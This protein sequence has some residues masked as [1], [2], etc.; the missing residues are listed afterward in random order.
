MSSFRW[1]GV[2]M[3][4]TASGSTAGLVGVD[5]FFSTRISGL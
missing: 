4:L 1:G 3:R 5:D 2:G